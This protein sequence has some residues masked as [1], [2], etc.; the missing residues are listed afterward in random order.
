MEQIVLSII[1]SGVLA[2][3]VGF[4]FG[5]RKAKAEVKSVELQNM[6]H[7]QEAYNTLFK[8][9]EVRINESIESNR[10]M[11]KYYNERIERYEARQKELKDTIEKLTISNRQLHRDIEKFKSEFPCVDFP[12]KNKT[13]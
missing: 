1:S 5:R 4:L 13:V 7:Y 3:I 12:R 11:R 6:N 2:S 8:D 10:Q 9:M